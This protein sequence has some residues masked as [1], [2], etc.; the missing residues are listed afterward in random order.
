MAETK[1]KVYECSNT[2]CS[3]GTL[4]SPG[5][6]T[7]GADK[8]RITMLTGNPEPEFF[9]EGVCP[10]CGQPGKEVKA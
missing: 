9:G 4:V 1:A 8:E 7:G 10:N 3:L 6:F 2:A 5:T